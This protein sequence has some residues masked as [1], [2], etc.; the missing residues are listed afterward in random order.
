[1]RYLS[2]PSPTAKTNRQR[3]LVFSFS[4]SSPVPT[5]DLVQLLVELG[6]L[7]ALPHDALPHE[8]GSLHRRKIPLVQERHGGCNESL[9]AGE[10]GEVR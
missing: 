6:E 5:C 7:G 3:H 10:R 9:W 8:E 2:S 1:M 4:A